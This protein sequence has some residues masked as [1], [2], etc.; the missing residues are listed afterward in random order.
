MISHYHR[1]TFFLSKL[2]TVGEDDGMTIDKASLAKLYINIFTS[3]SISFNC[4]AA[5]YLISV[6][7]IFVEKDQKLIDTCQFVSKYLISRSITIIFPYVFCC[8]KSIRANNR[9]PNIFIDITDAVLK[10]KEKRVCV[11]QHSA[12][13]LNSF[14]PNPSVRQRKFFYN[15]HFIG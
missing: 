1:K 10:G 13:S 12:L 4:Q 2:S 3:S 15:T 11:C 8:E 5:C 9:L 6:V 14:L 7:L